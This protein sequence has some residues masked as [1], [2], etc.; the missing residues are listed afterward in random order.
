MPAR[1]MVLDSM[2]AKIKG[3]AAVEV[4]V[5]VPQCCVGNNAKRGGG[6]SCDKPV[7]AIVSIRY[8]NGSTD[9]YILCR[10]HLED[11]KARDAKG[12]GKEGRQGAFFYAGS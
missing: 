2:E 10:G 3:R 12:L 5:V 6:R 7:V 8:N 1:P 11:L 9:V 4:A